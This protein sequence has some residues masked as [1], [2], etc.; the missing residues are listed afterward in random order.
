LGFAALIDGAQL[1]RKPQ[2]WEMPED[3]DVAALNS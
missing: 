1:I 2:G 3:D